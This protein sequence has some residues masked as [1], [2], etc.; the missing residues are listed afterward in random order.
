MLAVI[1][2]VQQLNEAHAAKVRLLLESDSAYAELTLPIF[3]SYRIGENEKT[4][5]EKSNL[6]Y[7]SFKIIE[8]L[9][10]RSILS[11]YQVEDM[12]VKDIMQTNLFYA[13]YGSTQKSKAEKR[14]EL[15]GIFHQLK[16]FK[17]EQQAA[18]LVKEL[19]KLHV[20]SPLE[21]VYDYMTKYYMNIEQ[22]NTQIVQ[23]YIQFNTLLGI[24]IDEKNPKFLKELIKKYKLIRKLT[25]K[26]ANQTA[27]SFCYISKLSLSTLADQSQ[28]LLDGGWT[29]S[30]LLSETKECIKNLPFGMLRFYLKNILAHIEYK[31]LVQEGNHNS[32][33]ELIKGFSSV[34]LI[35][36]YNFNFP[37]HIHENYFNE[38]R[39]EV[40][41]ALRKNKL[42]SS[43]NALNKGIA[44]QFSKNYFG[45]ERLSLFLN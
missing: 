21:A 11:F 40:E 16:R 30:T 10:Y 32:A 38:N 35:E 31:Q 15:E 1:E 42:A 20:N 14:F 23:H 24:Y 6:K 3:D 19:K 26:H 27:L 43:F 28:I 41:F 44:Y 34:S 36:A 33:I 29:I 17:I 39:T 25:S 37:N 5:Q 8:R 45:R 22:V 12:S 18:P 4:T 2:I 9:V 7:N 13:L